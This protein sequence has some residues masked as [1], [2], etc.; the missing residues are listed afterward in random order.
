MHTKYASVNLTHYKTHFY[1]FYLVKR[2]IHLVLFH[3]YEL[4]R[5]AHFLV[6]FFSN[7]IWALLGLP[8]TSF[9]NYA[10]SHLTRLTTH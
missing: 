6:E 8:S 5:F 2:W 9:H 7:F 10:L 3:S 4:T 1:S